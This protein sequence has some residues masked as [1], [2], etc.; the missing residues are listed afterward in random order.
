MA[1]ALPRILSLC[2]LRRP[3]TFHCP[4]LLACYRARCACVTY[5]PPP[6]LPTTLPRHITA[7]CA[8]TCGRR[9]L[10]CSAQVLPRLL[11][12]LRG[13]EGGGRQG[14]R[15]FGSFCCG[16]APSGARMCL[17]SGA[18]PSASVNSLCERACLS[19]FYAAPMP[20]LCRCAPARSCYYCRWCCSGL[21]TVL[22]ASPSERGTPAAAIIFCCR[23]AAACFS[24]PRKRQRAYGAAGGQRVATPCIPLPFRGVFSSLSAMQRC[25]RLPSGGRRAS[26]LLSLIAFAAVRGDSVPANHRRAPLRLRSAFAC[27]DNSF[28]ATSLLRDRDGEQLAG[29]GK[30]SLLAEGEDAARRL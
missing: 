24:L 30:N 17:S 29:M 28:C 8:W 23:A 11:L 4:L 19:A 16:T 21:Y 25:C 3:S 22:R 15:V 14:G 20:V 13:T 2:C 26:I 5:P 18:A 12:G 10:C 27:A 1:A 6:A 9:A 7:P